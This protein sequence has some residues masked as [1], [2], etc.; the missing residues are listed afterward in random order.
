MQITV[1]VPCSFYVLLL[2]RFF[3]GKGKSGFLGGFLS[4][5]FKK[6]TGV[7]F[8]SFFFKQ[9]CLRPTHEEKLV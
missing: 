4:V 6:N 8:G 9:P 1:Q 5:F 3:K 2:S 7:S